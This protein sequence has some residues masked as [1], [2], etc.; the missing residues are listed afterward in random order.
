[1]RYTTYDDYGNARNQ[2]KMAFLDHRAMLCYVR[3]RY[4]EKQLEM[5]NR[6]SP[7]PVTNASILSG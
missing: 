1:M 5:T 2:Y 4:G 7:M 6:L 3:R